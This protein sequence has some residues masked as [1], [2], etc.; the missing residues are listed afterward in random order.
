MAE[1]VGASD[2]QGGWYPEGVFVMDIAD[3]STSFILALDSAVEGGDEASCCSSVKEVLCNAIE[4]DPG[5]L[6]EAL[7]LPSKEGYARHLLHRDPKGRYSVVIMVWDQGQGT[8]LHDHSGMWCVEAV[9]RG[10]I[11]V[12][13]YTNEGDPQEDSEVFRFRETANIFSGV[14]E[15]GALIPPF[16]YHT[17]SNPDADLAVTIH[18]YGGEMDRCNTFLPEGED[19]FRRQEQSLV[20]TP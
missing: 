13:S 17:I 7:L 19:Y 1:I 9:Y 11:Q 14:G 20:Y 6:P 2:Y 3:S 12:I 15:A 16:D 4:R 8:P 10:R 18:V 5:F